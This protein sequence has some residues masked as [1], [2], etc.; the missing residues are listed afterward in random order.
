MRIQETSPNHALQLS[1]IGLQ[2]SHTPPPSQFAHLQMSTINRGL[3]RIDIPDLGWVNPRR[4]V[5]WQMKGLRRTKPW[6]G[7]QDTG[8]LAAAIVGNKAESLRSGNL[9]SSGARKSSSK[10]IA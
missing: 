3:E 9:Q 6:P 2:V 10:H 8:S 5:R 4:K 1:A 7:S